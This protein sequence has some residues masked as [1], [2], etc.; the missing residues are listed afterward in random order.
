[1]LMKRLLPPLSVAMQTQ[2][3]FGRRYS[4][5]PGVVVDVNPPDADILAANGWTHVSL[6]G[7]TAD[8]PKGTGCLNL[9]DARRGVHFFDTDVGAMLV[10]DGSSWRNVATGAA[11]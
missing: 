7:A 11:A 3:P 4:A 1:M 6:S 2:S 5:A 10:F 9:N 8:R